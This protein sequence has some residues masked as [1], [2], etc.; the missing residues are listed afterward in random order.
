YERLQSTSDPDAIAADVIASAK[1]TGSKAGSLDLS[2]ILLAKPTTEWL[3]SWYSRFERF[4]QA[5]RSTQI[6]S[7]Q[8]LLSINATDMI[9]YLVALPEKCLEDVRSIGPR[10]MLN[11]TAI[12][13]AVFRRCNAILSG[14]LLGVDAIGEKAVFLCQIGQWLWQLRDEVQ[15]LREL[16][17]LLK[18]IGCFD[19]WPS[20]RLAAKTGSGVVPANG[21]GSSMPLSPPLVVT[22]SKPAEIMAF[23]PTKTSRGDGNGKDATPTNDVAGSEQ[24][25]VPPPDNGGKNKDSRGFAG[26]TYGFFDDRGG[27]DFRAV[28]NQTREATE[29]VGYHLVVLQ[30]SVDQAHINMRIASQEFSS[31]LRKAL[32]S[33]S[34]DIDRLEAD[35]LD[36]ALSNASTDPTKACSRLEGY[37]QRLADLQED[38]SRYHHYSAF[39]DKDVVRTLAKGGAKNQFDEENMRLDLE[40]VGAERRQLVL[41]WEAQRKAVHI[42]QEWESSALIFC[43]ADV[44][45]S[46]LSRAVRAHAFAVET[47]GGVDEVSTSCEA[48]LAHLGRVVEAV[49][50]LH[51]RDLTAAYWERVEQAM[52]LREDLKR[53]ARKEFMPAIRHAAGLEIGPPADINDKNGESFNQAEPPPAEKGENTAIEKTGVAA[54]AGPAATDTTDSVTGPSSSG[55]AMVLSSV[56]TR[57]IPPKLDASGKL[58]VSKAAAVVSSVAGRERR[59]D[60][61]RRAEVYEVFPMAAEWGGLSLATLLS[62]GLLENIKVIGSISAEATAS[63]VLRKTLEELEGVWEAAPMIFLWRFN[64]GAPA[65]G[66]TKQSPAVD[67]D[68]LRRRRL[69]SRVLAEPALVQ[70]GYSTGTLAGVV[71]GGGSG[72]ASDLP[73]SEGYTSLLSNGDELLRLAEHCRLVVDSVVDAPSALLAVGNIGQAALEWQKRI[74][75]FQEILTNWMAVQEQWVRLAPAFVP[76]HLDDGVPAHDRVRF[77]DV[78][79]SFQN[80]LGTLRADT[81]M[82]VLAGKQQGVERGG[83]SLLAKVRKLQDDLEGVSITMDRHNHRW[84]SSRTAVCPRL[85]ALPRHHL[86]RLFRDWAAGRVGSG[87][88]AGETNERAACMFRGIGEILWK[89]V[90]STNGTTVRTHMAA[91][92]VRCCGAGLEAVPFLSPIPAIG[93]LEIWVRDFDRQLMSAIAEDVEI[94]A[95]SLRQYQAGGDFGHLGLRTSGLNAIPGLLPGSGIPSSSNKPANTATGERSGGDPFAVGGDGEGGKNGEQTTT[96]RQPSVQGQLLARG[97]YWTARIES[98][99]ACTTIS[100]PL[101]STDGG[102]GGGG[103]AGVSA[104]TNKPERNKL[105]D[106]LESLLLSLNAWSGEFSQPDGLT[107]YNSLT[108]T[109]LATQALQQRDVVEEL[110]QT[111]SMPPPSPSPAPHPENDGQ[112]RQAGKTLATSAASDMPPSS[113]TA[114]ST[115]SSIKE[116]R[117]REYVVDEEENYFLFLWACHLRHY[118]TSPEEVHSL[119]GRAQQSND[120]QTDNDDRSDRGAAGGGG[121]KNAGRGGY[122]DQEND[123]VPPPP[124]PL[125]RVSV[126]PWNVPY[127]FEYAGTLERLWLTPLSERCLLH[128]VHSAKGLYGGLLVSA[129]AQRH[130]SRQFDG[131]SGSF[132][133]TPPS[134]VDVSTAAL[135]VATAFGRPFRQLHSG[136][137]TSP[138]QAVSSVIAST[139]MAGGVT[140]FAGV[141]ELPKVSLAVL[142]ES[143]RAVMLCMHAGQ[144]KVLVNGEEVPLSTAPHLLPNFDPILH[145]WRLLPWGR[146][147]GAGNY[148]NSNN[149]GGGGPFLGF[150]ATLA[151]TGPAP[152]LPLSV[153]SAFRPVLTVLPNIP[154]ILEAML[155]SS[156]FVEARALVRGLV[157]GLRE[158]RNTP[159]T[160]HTRSDGNAGNPQSNGSNNGCSAGDDSVTRP[161]DPATLLHAVAVKAVRTAAELLAPET[162]RELRAA[163][164]KLGL[165]SL[166]SSERKEKTKHLSRAVEAR[167]LIAGFVRALLFEETGGDPRAL[168]SQKTKK[169]ALS[170]SGNTN[171][172]SSASAASASKTVFVDNLAAT[173]KDA[174]QLEMDARRAV[175]VSTFQKTQVLQ[176]ILKPLE[177]MAATGRKLAQQNVK[178]RATELAES[179]TAIRS[180]DV[181]GLKT[182]VKRALIINGMSPTK[183]Q[184]D[185]AAELWQALWSCS[186]PAVIMTGAAGIGKSSI[187]Q[188]MPKMAEHVDLINRKLNKSLKKQVPKAKKKQDGAEAVGATTQ[189]PN[190]SVL[191]PPGAVFEPPT[192]SR[193]AAPYRRIV[194]RQ[195][196]FLVYVNATSTGRKGGNKSDDGGTVAS[197]A[198][199]SSKGTKATTISETSNVSGASSDGGASVFSQRSA[200]TKSSSASGKSSS[201]GSGVAR[202]GKSGSGGMPPATIEGSA[203]VVP[204]QEIEVLYTGGCSA[205]H[206]IGSTDDK[207]CWL[208]GLL[209]RRLRA[210]VEGVPGG[211][212]T[213]AKRSRHRAC[214]VG[215]GDVCLP[216]A[217]KA[218]SGFSHGCRSRLLVLDGPISRVLEGILASDHAGGP[219]LTG[220]EECRHSSR[221]LLL[222]D[223]E[224]LALDAWGHV[225]V[226]TGDVRHLSPST[227]TGAAIV[228]LRADGPALVKGMR[229]AWLKKLHRRKF[230]QPRS[231][232]GV[233]SPVLLE[234]VSE[235][236]RQKDF[237]E[238]GCC[239][240][241]TGDATSALCVDPCTP[242]ST[243]ASRMRNTLLL[244]ERLLGVLVGTDQHAIEWEAEP[245]SEEN[246]PHPGTEAPAF[247]S[248]STRWAKL[249]TGF[250]ASHTFMQAVVPE[251]EM[252]KRATTSAGGLELEKSAGKQPGP[253]S[254]HP[255]MNEPKAHGDVEVD[256]P[257]RTPARAQLLIVAQRNEL[258]PAEI[259]EMNKRLRLRTFLLCVYASIWGMGGHLVGEASRVMCSAFIRQSSPLELRQHIRDNNLFDFVVDIEHTK[260]VPIGEDASAC[261]GALP[262]GMW[263]LDPHWVTQA[264]ELSCPLPP[265]LVIP[266][267]R[268]SSVA[269]A[270]YS[271]LG[272]DCARV[273]VQGPS[274]AGKTALL[275]HLLKVMG[276]G[277]PDVVAGQQNNQPAKQMAGDEAKTEGSTAGSPPANPQG[278]NPAPP[279]AAPPMNAGSNGSKPPGTAF[280]GE[281]ENGQSGLK[282]QRGAEK[283]ALDRRIHL[284]DSARRRMADAGTTIAAACAEAKAAAE[285][286][287]TAL[288]RN[289]NGATAHQVD[290]GPSPAGQRDRQPGQGFTSRH[291]G[292]TLPRSTVYLNMRRLG[293][294]ADIAGVIGRAL[295]R[296]KDGVLE[297]PQDSSTVV[298]LDDVHFAEEFPGEGRSSSPCGANSCPAET[299]RGM[300]D[301]YDALGEIRVSSTA[302]RQAEK[303]QWGRDHGGLGGGEAGAAGLPRMCQVHPDF[304]PRASSGP[305]G[306]SFS[307]PSTAAV[308]A[309][310][311]S[312]HS[313]ASGSTT[314]TQAYSLGSTTSGSGATLEPTAGAPARLG[315]MGS[316]NTGS[317]SGGGPTVPSLL[318]PLK[319]S[320]EDGQQGRQPPG[321]SSH[322]SSTDRLWTRF[323]ILALDA[324]S[325]CELRS[326]FSRACSDA[327]A[328]EGSV[329]SA[330]KGPIGCFSAATKT[331]VLITSEVWKAVDAMAGV[332]A[333][334]LQRLRQRLLEESSSSSKPSPLSLLFRGARQPSAGGADG[335]A[336]ASRLGLLWDTGAVAGGGVGEAACRL[337]YFSLGRLLRPLLLGRTGNISTPSAVQRFFTHEIMREVVEPLRENSQRKLATFELARLIRERAFDIGIDVHEERTIL[338]TWFPTGAETPPI[339]TNARGL[340]MAVAY[341]E[342][343]ATKAITAQ[344]TAG[345]KRVSKGSLAVP[346]EHSGGN[347]SY[348]E[349][350]SKGD[351]EAGN[352]SKTPP[353]SKG[354]KIPQTMVA[355]GILMNTKDVFSVGAITKYFARAVELLKVPWPA[356]PDSKPIVTPQDVT[357]ICK[358]LR[359]LSIP[360]NPLLVL[361]LESRGMSRE[362]GP[363]SAFRLASALEGAEMVVMDAGI[364]RM[365]AK[366][367]SGNGAGPPREASSRTFNAVL[368]KAVLACIGKTPQGPHLERSGGIGEDLWLNPGCRQSPDAAHAYSTSGRND[369]TTPATSGSFS[370]SSRDGK[371]G[372][373]SAYSPLTEMAGPLVPTK[374]VLLVKGKG[375]RR[376]TTSSDFAGAANLWGAGNGDWALRALM[377]LV[378]G[379][380]VRRLFS[381][382]ELLELAEAEE[383]HESRNPSGSGNMKN[384][385]NGHEATTDGGRAKRSTSAAVAAEEALS[386]GG[387]GDDEPGSSNSAQPKISRWS[388]WTR[389]GTDFVYRRIV[390]HIRQCLIVALCLDDEEVIALGPSFPVLSTCP[391]MRFESRSDRSMQL[392]AAR[393]LGADLGKFPDSAF[394]TDERARRELFSRPSSGFDGKSRVY[395]WSGAT[396]ANLVGLLAFGRFQSTV[397][398]FKDPPTIPAGG[399]AER[400]D[401]GSVAELIENDQFAAA[402]EAERLFDAWMASADPS[403]CVVVFRAVEECSGGSGVGVDCDGGTRSND[404]CVG[405]VNVE[406]DGSSRTG[407]DEGRWGAVKAQCFRAM[408]EEGR[409][410]RPASIDEVLLLFKHLCRLGCRRLVERAQVLNRALA[411]AEHWGVHKARREA[412]KVQLKKRAKDVLDALSQNNEQVRHVQQEKTKVQDFWNKQNKSTREQRQAQFLRMEEVEKALEPI[413]AAYEAS[414]DLL[415]TLQEEDMEF[416]CT[417]CLGSGMFNSAAGVS[418]HVAEATQQRKQKGLHQELPFIVETVAVMLGNMSGY[419][420]VVGEWVRLKA[421]PSMKIIRALLLD[422]TIA[423]RLSSFDPESET[424]QRALKLVIEQMAERSAADMSKTKVPDGVPKGAPGRH[425]GSREGGS[426]DGS[427]DSCPASSAIH[428]V[429]RIPILALKLESRACGLLASWVQATVVLFD[430]LCTAAKS[431]AEI[432]ADAKA[433][434]QEEERIQIGNTDEAAPLDEELTLRATFKSR[435]SI[436]QR[437]INHRSDLNK[438]LGIMSGA[439]EDFAST[440]RQELHDLATTAELFAGDALCFANMACLGAHLPHT[441]RAIALHR[442]RDAARRYGIPTSRPWV[443]ASKDQKSAA[444]STPVPNQE[445]DSDDTPEPKT[446]K[447]VPSVT[448]AL[449][450]ERYRVGNFASGVLTNVTQLQSWTYPPNAD[451]ADDGVEES[452]DE[453]DGG[454]GG[455]DDDADASP[456]KSAGAVTL[457]SLPFHPAFMDAAILTLSTPK[458]PLVLDP[459][460]IA[461]RW[462]RGVYPGNSRLEALLPASMVSMDIIAA[463]AAKGEIL[464]V[465][466]T[467]GGVH[468]DLALF[469]GSNVLPIEAA[470]NK[471]PPR[472]KQDGKLESNALGNGGGTSECYGSVT[473]GEEPQSSTTFVVKMGFRLIL[474]A[475]SLDFANPQR[476]KSPGNATSMVFL[477]DSPEALSG[478]Q[479]IRFGGVDSVGLAAGDDGNGCSFDTKGCES[480]SDVTSPDLVAGEE[481]SGLSAPSDDNESS[482]SGS[483]EGE[484][485]IIPPFVT[486]GMGLRCQPGLEMSKTMGSRLQD[487]MVRALP[488]A[489]EGSDERQEITSRAAFSIAQ[490]EALAYSCQLSATHEAVISLLAARPPCFTPNVAR[491]A[492]DPTVPS[493]GEPLSGVSD[494]V[495]RDQNR[496]LNN[497]IETL[498]AYK[499]TIEKGPDMVSRCERASQAQHADAARKDE[500]VAYRLTSSALQFLARSGDVLHACGSDPVLYSPVFPG[501]RALVYGAI[502]RVAGTMRPLNQDREGDLERVVA[503]SLTRSMITRVPSDCTW[504][505]PLAALAVNNPDD[506]PAKG[507][508][509]AFST[510]VADRRKGSEESSEDSSRISLA[511]LFKMVTA[512][513]KVGASDNHAGIA[514]QSD[515]SPGRDPGHLEAHTLGAG[516]DESATQGVNKVQAV[517]NSWREH[518]DSDG[519][520]VTTVNDDK[521]QESVREAVDDEESDGDETIQPGITLSPQRW[522][523]GFDTSDWARDGGAAAAAAYNSNQGTPFGIEDGLDG[524]DERGPGNFNS[525]CFSLSS[526]WTAAVS[527]RSKMNATQAVQAKAFSGDGVLRR[528]VLLEA[529]MNSVFARLPGFVLCE[530]SKWSEWICEVCRSLSTV[531]EGCGNN[532][533]IGW[534]RFLLSHPPPVFES[535]HSVGDANSSSSSSVSTDSNSGDS[536]SGSTSST[537]GEIGVGEAIDE[538]NTK[539]GQVSETANDDTCSETGAAFSGEFKQQE[540]RGAGAPH[541]K[542]RR[543]SRERMKIKL[544]LVDGLGIAV[545]SEHSDEI[546]SAETSKEFTARASSLF[547]ISTSRSRGVASA[548]KLPSSAAANRADA[549]RDESLQISRTESV[550]TPATAG[551]TPALLNASAHQE[552]DTGED[553]E[554][555][556][557]TFVAETFR[558]QRDDSDWHK[559]E[560]LVPTP[561]ETTDAKNT[562]ALVVADQSIASVS[563]TTVVED[564]MT[565]MASPEDKTAKTQMI[566]QQMT[567]EA[568]SSPVASSPPTVDHDGSATAAALGALP[569]RTTVGNPQQSPSTAEDSVTAVAKEFSARG[570]LSNDEIA[571]RWEN[572]NASRRKGNIH[573]SPAVRVVAFSAM[574]PGKKKRR[575]VLEVPPEELGLWP[576]RWNESPLIGIVLLLALAPDGQLAAQ[577]AAACLMA[578]GGR[579][580]LQRSSL[581]RELKRECAIGISQRGRIQPTLA[582]SRPWAP[583]VVMVPAGGDMTE[584]VSRHFVS[585]LSNIEHAAKGAGTT[586]TVHDASK[587]AHALLSRGVLVGQARGQQTGHSSARGRGNPAAVAING[588]LSTTNMTQSAWDVCLK[589]ATEGGWIVMKDF[590]GAAESLSLIVDGIRRHSAVR[591]TS[592]AAAEEQEKVQ[593]EQQALVKMRRT[594]T[595]PRTSL[596]DR[597]DDSFP[598]HGLDGESRGAGAVRAGERQGSA[599]IR[600]LVRP[601]VARI[602]NEVSSKM[603]PDFPLLKALSG[604]EGGSMSA[605]VQPVTAAAL[606]RPLPVPH[607]SFRIILLSTA[608]SERRARDDHRSFVMGESTVIWWRPASACVET[609]EATS[610]TGRL[611]SGRNLAMASCRSE[612]VKELLGVASGSHALSEPDPEVELISERLTRY[613]EAE[614]DGQGVDGAAVNMHLA[615]S[616]IVLQQA[617]ACGGAALTTAS[618]LLYPKALAGNRNIPPNSGPKQDT[619]GG[620]VAASIRR[621][622]K[623]VDRVVDAAAR[624]S[625]VATGLSNATVVDLVAGVLDSEATHAREARLVGEIKTLASRRNREVASTSSA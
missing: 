415:S 39:L 356:R 558:P 260:L 61:R 488:P 391:S 253:S 535:K 182:L 288:A 45:A 537:S 578:E 127:G 84:L 459:E 407:Q 30:R 190:A 28:E 303:E 156:G 86:F 557:I 463:C 381:D 375:T 80:I 302:R 598:H 314:A 373:S 232:G 304:A 617:G 396:H 258:T 462:L 229:E 56:A 185:A 413:M 440:C 475:R 265:S 467:E 175:M 251:D 159:A 521:G 315:I 19:A 344:K 257:T 367:E 618:S 404:A 466:S 471:K 411:A 4:R 73:A 593:R 239:L 590:G 295:R 310:R 171:S 18:K 160:C 428:Y 457:S 69:Y 41:K 360:W 9:A 489:L 87:A 249:S 419:P 491:R 21:D 60:A 452:G 560:K 226:E 8:A 353:T 597:K 32:E 392:V 184:I 242:A 207:G 417:L 333:D 589:A 420:H 596:G 117:D 505:V 280:F 585:V 170:T 235:F 516:Q 523:L 212:C 66:I 484:D 5:V 123:S 611:T 49:G 112:G 364:G 131:T 470:E 580:N 473:V 499:S 410:P 138:Q 51:N 163:R 63:A 116:H 326:V 476:L 526:L 294:T 189:H 206:L 267:Q 437:T 487:E 552:F 621:Q 592:I 432:Q 106:V 563:T 169:P 252:E 511:K 515:C 83:R 161:A 150:F 434:H 178:L 198:S 377:D 285:S 573:S 357:N 503:G 622:R 187:L 451:V 429:K 468:I 121:T 347:V 217:G 500:Q 101:Q 151:R 81:C 95:N 176:E 612:I 421:S 137:V 539:R 490:K 556:F 194:N 323:A 384:S 603:C 42:R 282:Q 551:T 368:R 520:K 10:L 193:G 164:R 317:A 65:P 374:T 623:Q 36:P 88:A 279:K 397:P 349:I 337:D 120:L 269:T 7:P 153:R 464:P 430:A 330:V 31:L 57:V 525:F 114:R 222:P 497:L 425:S 29:N 216:P 545:G 522:D 281:Q 424:G 394:G 401:I 23:S 342:Q 541:S 225:A 202:V 450:L 591:N 14:G 536:D 277:I 16:G 601:G 613:I 575:Q 477:E 191:D 287:T 528:L 362:G 52:P 64:E 513:D 24:Q 409:G 20:P 147:R 346:R 441:L 220:P 395:L 439:I 136:C 218:T 402:E 72:G 46:Q 307:R 608:S 262:R 43:D 550:G 495:E 554:S 533:S 448:S 329:C 531:R 405:G 168:K 77:T 465:C 482:N 180:R 504:V 192:N 124:P 300:I 474:F 92:G 366:T 3:H 583:V 204:A 270:A 624:A 97:A 570:N 149:G 538:E 140:V 177:D 423:E 62:H 619:V 104:A 620:D 445:L 519:P 211:A 453:S 318:S 48:T 183:D 543:D 105:Q 247:K 99:L 122:E 582:N 266:S 126:G 141:D 82:T 517:V 370:A 261:P 278:I 224:A 572:L 412:E 50:F 456:V 119:N 13:G 79:G 312:L 610:V 553:E 221:C 231:G 219:P 162:A 544:G 322:A 68:S 512:A 455:G 293:T 510:L 54:S 332:T 416:L 447:S 502:R 496:V 172:T 365:C 167:V 587:P 76:E 616:L 606:R 507:W 604:G 85:L 414:R 53:A 205:E 609:A 245:A 143:L 595:N 237:V 110:L 47:A 196:P 248:L 386:L 567:S 546:V 454:R 480:S 549:D 486:G 614:A 228:H 390:S 506:F 274:G 316:A 343:Q 301:G 607:K 179:G 469:L 555:K 297:A 442:A 324:P 305:V 166:T 40:R 146:Q 154:L 78:S 321:L 340:V 388:C 358:C 70:Q 338:E 129:S 509:D 98:A 89:E 478:V 75:W 311:T 284:L 255:R 291:G 34:R 55:T 325:T 336:A 406:M 350:C 215:S 90:V 530:A 93:R 111:V 74:S 436:R 565:S 276:K 6:D 382:A 44:M 566:Q 524:P 290:P 518:H 483:K 283:V 157:G 561:L 320:S 96:G 213:T 599:T 479:L 308:L 335:Q 438:E 142:A 339:W 547:G 361:R 103:A 128:A 188:A 200:A 355:H 461:L 481:T 501:V 359:Q 559:E 11:A 37:R 418:S 144:E 2:P 444:T 562:V 158:L 1:R 275:S 331:T 263:T 571:E 371:T 107:A 399:T 400:G 327:F 319:R 203:F 238:G 485:A 422:P 125:I 602:S 351:E 173:P 313:P 254:F 625:T 201:A 372:L 165:A 352:E 548:K 532:A 268:L 581:W 380:D 256:G 529:T 569:E 348:L 186:R 259:Q 443:D 354:A 498:F 579:D 588:G 534:L 130:R 389:G 574:L 12:L 271:L 27:Y 244:L 341:W 272:M 584:A 152:Q 246:E 306:D 600:Q 71:G 145:Q 393:S 58:R 345:D 299:I 408:A 376:T 113:P 398:A 273:L 387:V 132:L 586:V 108:I 385:S 435:L 564:D 38:E 236:F 91:T 298:F 210:L 328:G 243:Y 334:F 109:A 118:F 26:K 15:K 309:A 241:D 458:W 233:L 174:G 286:G 472:R 605:R 135:D 59:G 102:N 363:E 615:A 540:A 223:G 527:D 492:P 296:E 155:L 431:R 494:D 139:L 449:S 542:V 383:N 426:A 594:T 181:A 133:T 17:I 403:A 197:G 199:G 230:Q 577:C 94:A 234:V 33:L 208:D 369:A 209:V 240:K 264:S 378:E 134:P 148:Y 67:S 379:G 25:T 115:P 446:G 227:I 508:W 292:R 214:G 250:R 22:A 493:G 576:Q 433:T 195:V 427:G 100:E 568:V 514:L 289:N 460:G 35:I